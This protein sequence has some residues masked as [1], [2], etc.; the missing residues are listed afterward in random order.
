MRSTS[1][2]NTLPKPPKVRFDR[3]ALGA[4]S[5]LRAVSHWIS[6]SPEIPPSATAHELFRGFSFVN[7]RLMAEEG[8]NGNAVSN[9]AGNRDIV[10]GRMVDSILAKVNCPHVHSFFIIRF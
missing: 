10:S 7:T 2:R 5:F 9:I 4:I 6:D 1:I 8:N 3:R